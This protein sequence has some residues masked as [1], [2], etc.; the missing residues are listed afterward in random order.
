MYFSKHIWFG[1]TRV[2]LVLLYQIYLDF[3]V[4]IEYNLE[5]FLEKVIRQTAKN[6]LISS[7]WAENL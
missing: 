3:K 2:A 6:Y 7:I 5:I 4:K 1:S